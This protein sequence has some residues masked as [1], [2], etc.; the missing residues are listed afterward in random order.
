MF[1]RNEAGF[2]LQFNY[3]DRRDAFHVT[4]GGDRHFNV[5]DGSSLLTTAPTSSASKGF[6]YHKNF[7]DNNYW[8]LMANGHLE[9]RGYTSNST[10]A[11]TIE[12]CSGGCIPTPNV[13]NVETRV[14][15]WS[16]DAD[17]EGGT[18]PQAGQSGVIL[19]T[20]NMVYDIESSAAVSY[21]QIKIE[22]RLTFED[23]DTG[24][25]TYELKANQIIITGE[26]FIGSETDSYKANALVTLLGTPNMEGYTYS[27]GIHAGNK[28]L[29]VG[30][31]LIVNGK[32]KFSTI[33]DPNPI[34]THLKAA[35]TKGSNTITLVSTTGIETNDEI[36]IAPTS[37]DYKKTEKKKV[38]A[39]NTSTGV[40]TLD[41]NLEHDHFGADAA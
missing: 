23:D 5:T 40:V 21:D 13:I 11:V 36:V 10:L 31:K 12:R 1:R 37:Y 38:T 27:T 35:A 26:M 29:F 17:W 16:V 32:D 15:K 19:N 9:D 33:A 3:T 34:F 2:V 22:G 7:V 8:R 28:I 18:K 39:V 14:R 30:G 6:G 24:A 20:W 41:S 4:T 25:K